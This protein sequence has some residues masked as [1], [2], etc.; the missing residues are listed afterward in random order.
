[1]VGAT[2]GALDGRVRA[3]GALTA[4]L[5]LARVVAVEMLTGADSTSGGGS[6][7]ISA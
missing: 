2:I 7:Y 6:L 4:A 3:G 1:V 5:L